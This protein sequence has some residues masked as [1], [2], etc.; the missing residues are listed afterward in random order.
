[1][2]EPTRNADA[3]PD[4]TRP[5][6]STRD[7]EDLRAA[8]EPWLVRRTGATDVEISDVRTPQ[9]NGMSSE[10]LLFDAR[11]TAP[12]GESGGEEQF[13]QCVARLAPASDAMPI[14]PEYRMRDQFTVMALVGERTAVPVPRT[15]W[16]ES[17][18]EVL[19]AE[20]FVMER[21]EGLV[22]PDILPYTFGDNWLAQA[23]DGQRRR[24]QDSTVA[25]LARIHAIPA[26]AEEVAFLGDLT[27][28]GD[29]ALRAHVDGWRDYYSWAH[30][31]QPIPILEK[32]FAWLDAH[33]P[34]TVDTPV[35][36]WGD[37]RIGNI[38]YRDF[39]PA[40]VL[41]WEMAGIAPREVDLG[42]LTFLHRF[43]QDIA[44]FFGLPGLPGFLDPGDVA[45][46]YAA[47]TGY[48]VRDPRF[49]EVYAALRHGIV[50]GRVNQRRVRFG[51]QEAPDEPD[52]LVN[53]AATLERMLDGGYWS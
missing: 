44:E 13:R 33:W 32:T 30:G 11:W 36:S 1:M 34:T 27:A 51:E 15:L 29:T 7:P 47:R 2:S 26:T 52:G 16:Y 3:A 9:T 18:P 42:W 23:T 21:V 37:A 8:L 6:T 22:P 50:M 45:S 39:A 24:L 41:D 12:P 53:H 48:R 40:A 14:F 20:F 10:T 5:Q 17:D 4:V 38:M 35:L 46:E 19:G 43:F 25:T 49:Y 28:D 31:E